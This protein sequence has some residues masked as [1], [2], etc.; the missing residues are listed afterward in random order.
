MQENKKILLLFLLAPFGCGQPTN[1]MDQDRTNLQAMREE[2]TALIREPVCIGVEDCRV[3]GVG[4]KPCGGPWEYLVYSVMVTDST[5]LANETRQYNE[6]EQEFNER[7]DVVS[8]CDLL[9]PPALGCTNNRCV[10]VD[11]PWQ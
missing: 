2:I 3:V 7:H 10:A 11:L 5:E 4:S 9:M 8:T 6:A 1:S